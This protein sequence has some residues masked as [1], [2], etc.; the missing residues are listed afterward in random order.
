MVALEFGPNSSY[1]DATLKALSEKLDP[2][3]VKFSGDPV[4]ASGKITVAPDNMCAYLNITEPQNGGKPLTVEQIRQL[5][6]N[7]GIKHGLRELTVSQLAIRPMYGRNLPIA[8][9][10]PP[11][12]GKDGALNYL[13]RL[14]KDAAPT[15]RED[16][17]VDYKDLGLTESVAKDQTLCVKTPPDS[18][19][20]GVTVMGQELPSLPGKDIPLPVGKNTYLSEDK[21]E[22]R[23]SIDGQC[24][25][26]ERR[27]MVMETFFVKGDV[28]IAT[29]NISVAGN[30]EIMGSVL[31]G[32]SVKAGGNI[33]INGSV[34]GA[35]LTAGGNIVIRDGFI[36]MN[37][38]EII[39]G[40]SLRCKYIQGG[41]VSAIGLIETQTIVSAEVRS[42]DSVIMPGMRSIIM[43]G[44]VTAK[45]RID[46]HRIGNPNNPVRTV[47]EA[48]S[49]PTLLKRA[50]E[51]GKE[52]EQ[53]TKNLYGL[54]N[55]LT[56]C[57]RLKE[58]NRLTEEKREV[59]EKAAH[60]HRTVSETLAALKD[61]AEDVKLRLALEGYGTIIGRTAIYPEV[62][63]IIG[64]EQQDIQITHQA[65][66]FTRGDDGLRFSACV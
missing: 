49:D 1:I 22:L 14:T 18:G 29:G 59:M 24:D 32:F 19:K 4:D 52:T 53:L 28:S 42:S 50:N 3:V 17:S 56:M 54:D 46:C 62:R 27:L 41:R 48:G 57:N 63:V 33:N 36:G 65:A 38:G 2:P 6:A 15:V 45:N 21:L 25:F 31:T 23:A 16:G 26:V 8:E 66:S 39:A 10:T 13:V 58:Q 40:G 12:K 64:G 61:E 5:A 11:V 20:N 60:T 30:V 37:K 51:I 34:E 47:V 55:I 43:G 44:R 9:G 35:S 7:A